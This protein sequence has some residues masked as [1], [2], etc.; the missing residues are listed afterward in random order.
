MAKLQKNSGLL[1]LFSHCIIYAN[2]A[3]VNP[4][5]DNK[6]VQRQ[7]QRLRPDARPGPGPGSASR[8]N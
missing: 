2:H 5:K 6:D 8:A 4:F 3:V 1:D 7:Q